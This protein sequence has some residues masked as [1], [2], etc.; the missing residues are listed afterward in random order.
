VTRNQDGHAALLASTALKGAT[1]PLGG[2]VRVTR[3]VTV[4]LPFQQRM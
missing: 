1:A 2:I 3:E 4:G